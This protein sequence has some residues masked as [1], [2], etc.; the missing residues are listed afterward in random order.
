M[1]ELAT[2]DHREHEVR[3]LRYLAHPQL[4]YLGTQRPVKRS[5]DFPQVQMLREMLQ[6]MKTAGLDGGVDD[7]IPVRMRPAGYAAAKSA[8]H[9]TSPFPCFALCSLFI[10]RRFALGV[11][12]NIFE[13]KRGAGNIQ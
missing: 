9:G 2:E 12:M 1:R 11:N 8:L 10:L 3:M 4:G 6:R 13:R 5:I 7:R